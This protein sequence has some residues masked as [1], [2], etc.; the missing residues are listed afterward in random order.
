LFGEGS[1]VLHNNAVPAWCII[2]PIVVLAGLLSWLT[3]SS[4]EIAQWQDEL[5]VSDFWASLP[6]ALHKQFNTVV[7][8]IKKEGN[9]EENIKELSALHLAIGQHVTRQCLQQISQA[10]D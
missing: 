6:D 9:T 3:S 7:S 10:L 8:R 5:D 4:K 2:V 1:S